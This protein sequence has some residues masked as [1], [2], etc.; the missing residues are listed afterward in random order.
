MPE[1]KGK[2]G[3]STEALIE[4]A[5]HFSSAGRYAEALTFLDQAIARDPAAVRAYIGRASS[6]VQL[7]R[8]AEGLASAQ[9]AI[10]LD[11]YDALGYTVVGL[12][13]HR[14]GRGEEARLAYETAL[15]MAPENPRVLYNVACYQAQLGDEEKCREFLTR[16]FQYWESDVVDRSK[17]DGDLAPYIGTDWFAELHAA[18]KTLEEGVEDFLAGRY[19]A[20]LAAFERILSIN[21]RHVRAHVGRSLALAQLGRADE[22]LA[23]A[24]EVIRLNPDYVRGYSAEASCLHRLRRRAEAEAAYERA[25]ELAPDDPTVLYN[26]ACFWAEIGDEENCR[27]YLSR[28]LQHDDGRATK[29]APNDPDMARYRS[30]EWFRDLIAAAKR[31]RRPV[32]RGGPI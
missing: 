11:P 24:Q 8:P 32:P 22:G 14:L 7:E 30:A 4:R 28:A 20:A 26:F 2:K 18:A 29:H 25:V 9:K 13:L 1:A 10:R 3:E 15:T 19:D 31:S 21:H 6:L 16:A 27:E 12:C 17:K 23:A 5:S